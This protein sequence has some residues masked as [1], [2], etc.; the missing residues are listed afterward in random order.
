MTE[1]DR[2]S[3]A[4]QISLRL[5][6]FWK[7]FPRP[8]DAPH[9]SLAGVVFCEVRRRSGSLL[10]PVALHWAINAVGYVTAFLVTRSRVRPT[11]T[12]GRPRR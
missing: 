3:A 8:S 12:P 11:G 2:Q 1:S 7:A 9:M 6:R 4:R 5:P 10:A